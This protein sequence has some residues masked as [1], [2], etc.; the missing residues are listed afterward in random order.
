MMLDR[1]REA[2][3]L[4]DQQLHDTFFTE[5]QGDQRRVIGKLWKAKQNI[6]WAQMQIL[7][8]FRGHVPEEGE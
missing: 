2:M 8:A 6:W 3:G 4:I 5:G 7:D 1:L